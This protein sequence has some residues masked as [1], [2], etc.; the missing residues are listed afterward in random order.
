MR[1]ELITD[2]GSCANAERKGCRILKDVALAASRGRVFAD[3]DA[4][5]H[6]RQ[7]PRHGREFEHDDYDDSLF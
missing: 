7:F 2:S 6:V 5:V 1:R 3:E 4:V